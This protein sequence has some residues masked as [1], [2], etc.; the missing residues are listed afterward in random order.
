MAEVAAAALAAAAA[1][2]ALA[3]AAVALAAA[4]AAAV[5]AAGSGGGFMGAIGSGVQELGQQ[6]G[7]NPAMRRIGDELGSRWI[8]VKNTFQQP[9]SI[10]SRLL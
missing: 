3:A 4:A 7:A 8:D 6:L 9:G 5:A 2:A 10:P 1:A